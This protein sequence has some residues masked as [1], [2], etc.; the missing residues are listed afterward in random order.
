MDDESDEEHPIAT[1]HDDALASIFCI[2]S[3]TVHPKQKS[4]MQNVGC[5][6]DLADALASEMEWTKR[7]KQ[8]ICCGGNISRVRHNNV[9]GMGRLLLS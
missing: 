1:S 3:C 2:P 7:T 6:L 9:Q 5:E 8:S 4:N